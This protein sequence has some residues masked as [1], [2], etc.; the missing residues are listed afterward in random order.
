MIVKN[1]ESCL[2]KCLNSVKGFDEIVLC[3]TGSEDDTIKIA[4]KYTSK[5]F[6]DFVWCDDFAKARNHALNKCSGDWILTIDADE[7]LETPISDVYKVVEY[8]E[9]NGYEVVNCETISTVG[10]KHSTPRL[11]KR[12][13]NIFWKGAIHNYLNKLGDINFNVV[14][15]YG[16]SEAHKKDPDRAL[17]ILKK[18]V[19][20]KKNAREMY[21]LARE[22][23]YRDDYITALY[24]YDEY[25][26]I[27]EF[28]AEKADANLMAARCAWNL[29]QGDKARQYCLN[30]I[31]INAN[32]KEALLFMATLSWEKNAKQWRLMAESATNEDVLF[33]RS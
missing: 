17:R 11:Y 7:V 18:E 6:T 16:Y 8:A 25:L 22:Y 19:A 14:I 29:S 21:Y 13:P 4:K 20:E 27:S 31:S 32:F 23:W 5:V 33:I 10:D 1:E 2:S 3:D 30:A 26:K 24:W 28:L 12:S 15:R 9:K